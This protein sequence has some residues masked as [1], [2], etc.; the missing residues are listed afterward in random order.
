MVFFSMMREKGRSIFA[1]LMWLLLLIAFGDYALFS[2]ESSNLSSLLQ[3]SSDGITTYTA[4]QYALNILM[5]VVLIAVGIFT[6]K[7][8]R[9]ITVFVTLILVIT[10][11]VISIKDLFSINKA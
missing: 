4:S 5:I 7:K 11:T 9:K 2:L 6:Y 10:L 3:Y 8:F 1:C